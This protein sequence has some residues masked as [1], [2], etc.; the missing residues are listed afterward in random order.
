LAV[1][2]AFLINK[3]TAVEQAAVDKAVAMYALRGMEQ[4]VPRPNEEAWARNR[5][6]L[7][8][9]DEKLKRFEAAG[10]DVQSA[11]VK[12][13]EEQTRSEMER[14]ALMQALSKNNPGKTTFEMGGP[15]TQKIYDEIIAN[16]SI[17]TNRAEAFTCG[18]C[19]KSATEKLLLCS[20][21]RKVSYC[22]KACQNASWKAHKKLC[23]P[24]VAV[25]GEAAKNPKTLPLTWKE[26]EAHGV[27]NP[28]SGR[29]L[30]VRAMLD[31]SMTRQVFSCKDRSG[32]VRRVAAYT[33]SGT[34]PGL[35]QGS[36]LRWKNPRYHYFMDGSSGARIEETDLVNI[37]VV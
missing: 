17:K 19:N 3:T 10:E 9:A 6:Y 13:I 37:T 28:V 35:K 24:V 30:E 1:V 36:I 4:M 18:Y 31:E 32:V 8:R 7:R 20:R 23:V 16:P 21:C 25:D 12:A 29:K 22:D 34:I 11:M 14:N 15:E 2:V 26:V 33:N 27:G 5:E